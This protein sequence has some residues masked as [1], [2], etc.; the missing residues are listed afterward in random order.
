MCPYP[1]I[2]PTL[3]NEKYPEGVVPSGRKLLCRHGRDTIGRT[4]KRT[5]ICQKESNCLTGIQEFTFPD[6]HLVVDGT[7]SSDWTD[8]Q[9]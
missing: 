9:F 5:I 3:L 6:R 7:V 2:L 1:K 8:F 4:Q